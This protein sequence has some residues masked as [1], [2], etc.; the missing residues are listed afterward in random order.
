V[1]T[2]TGGPLSHTAIIAR[3]MNLPA[4]MGV[5]DV[6]PGLMSGELVIVDGDAGVV[7]RA[8]SEATIE[9]YNTRAREEA[10]TRR[11]QHRATSA[12]CVTKDRI[13]I[14]LGSNINFRDEVDLAVANECETIGL[15]RTEFDFFRDGKPQSEDQL[16]EDYAYVLTRARGLNV[17]IRAVD[18]GREGTPG[19]GPVGGARGLRYLLD[20]RSLFRRQLRAIFRASVHGNAR[21]LL[22]FVSTLDELVEAKA[23]VADVRRRLSRAGADFDDTVPV[24]IM[25]ETPAAAETCDLMAT[26]VDFMCLGTNDLI[27]YLLAVDRTDMSH[28]DVLDPYHPA[29]LRVLGHVQ[30]LTEPTGKPILVCGELAADP[31]S[32]AVLLGMGFTRLSVNAGA[33]PRIKRMIRSVAISDLRELVDGLMSMRSRDRI[34]RQVRDTLGDDL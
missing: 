16:Y 5:S 25:I 4:V 6:L 31:Y 12:P 33:F 28:L 15:Y 29:V 3:S 7:I 20:N 1:V 19:S 21:I 8:P 26:E 11:R 13:S 27:Q 17:N 30:S 34:E 23:I 14:L 22:P 32:A 2:E 9:A 10:K 18:A 24:G